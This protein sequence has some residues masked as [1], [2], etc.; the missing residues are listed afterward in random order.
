MRY[1]K[2]YGIDIEGLSNY[3]IMI[4]TSDLSIAEMNNIAERV[5][6]HFSRNFM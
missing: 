5:V 4:D 6:A 3:D 1:K 2:Y